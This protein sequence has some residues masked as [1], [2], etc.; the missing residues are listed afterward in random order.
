M[1]RASERGK[2]VKLLRKILSNLRASP[3][4]AK[5]GDLNNA[6][7]TKKI[8]SCSPALSLLFAVGFVR[9]ADG[10]RLKWKDTQHNRKRL[11]DI[12][13][14]LQA[15]E[16]Q[17]NSNVNKDK[18]REKQIAELMQDG[19]SRQQAEDAFQMSVGND[20]VCRCTCV[21]ATQL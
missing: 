21:F 4:N 7:I 18:T 1:L 16:G 14:A 13:S 17:Q 11:S 6:K 2:A 5:F 12:Y 15:E 3:T 20:S 8:S 10:E 19:Y 9:S